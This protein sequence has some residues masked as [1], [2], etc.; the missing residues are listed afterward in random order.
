MNRFLTIL[1]TLAFTL[2]GKVAQN[3]NL[4]FNGQFE[5]ER[6]DTPPLGWSCEGETR[7]LTYNT[8]GGPDNKPFISLKNIGEPPT[9]NEPLL[10]Q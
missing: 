8:S 6:T 5:T 3:E 7:Y 9:E 1:L 10:R 2:F 4:L